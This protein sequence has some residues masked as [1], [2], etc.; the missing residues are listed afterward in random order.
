M[1][2]T[3]DRQAN[4][5]Y[6]HLTD[7]VLLGGLSTT[8]ADTPPGVKAS[9]ALDWMAERLIGIEILDANAFLPADLLEHAEI[10][11]G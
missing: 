4:A 9:I 2:I 1:R 3:Y 6:L 11:D 10:I 5:A 7:Q 8:T